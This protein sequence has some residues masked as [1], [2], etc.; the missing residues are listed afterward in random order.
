MNDSDTKHYE[1][2]QYTSSIDL[3][4]YHVVAVAWD[5][6]ERDIN[7]DSLMYKRAFTEGTKSAETV[8]VELIDRT[9]HSD[10]FNARTLEQAH[11]LMVKG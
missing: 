11:A 7:L 5:G 3:V 1:L 6:S 2:R 9:S 4:R 8:G 10:L